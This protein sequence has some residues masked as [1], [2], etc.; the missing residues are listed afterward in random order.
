MAMVK[1][2]CDVIEDF[3]RVNARYAQRLYIVDNGSEDGTLAIL[4]NL[5]QE[6]LPLSVYQHNSA[7]FQQKLVLN[8]LLRQMMAEAPYRYVVAL[9]ADEFITETADELI[10]AFDQ[11]P[12][13]CVP[14]LPWR[15]Y[16]PVEATGAGVS[17]RFVHRP[18]AGAD[19]Y[20]VVVP[21]RL[22]A[23]GEISEG[24]HLFSSEGRVLPGVALPVVIRHVPVRSA[25]Q[26]IAKALVGSHRLAVKPGRAP[27]EGYHWDQIAEFIRARNYQLG[28]QDLEAIA[29]AYP[30]ITP[31]DQLAGDAAD[32]VPL[33]IEGVERRYDHLCRGGT[34]LRLDAYIKKLT[35]QLIKQ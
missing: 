5:V 17:R 15:N 16:F 14:Y 1:D 11:V 2:E 6:G 8:S 12:E 27:G 21:G 20:K 19:V 28:L 22:A 24:N 29:C 25:E 23:L 3:V 33:A 7:H 26:I 9:D 10:A 31:A 4:A 18:G 34:V 35:E 30:A 32:C 13:N